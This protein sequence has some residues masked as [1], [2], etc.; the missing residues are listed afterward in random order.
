MCSLTL[1]LLS[2]AAETF[3]GS[4]CFSGWEFMS[5]FSV[6]TSLPSADCPCSCTAPVLN[7]HTFFHGCGVN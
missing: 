4:L 1:S 3:Q 6:T 7:Q 2:F 5:A